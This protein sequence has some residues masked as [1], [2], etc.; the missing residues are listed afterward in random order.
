MS[1]DNR[2]AEVIEAGTTL[3]TA[4]CYELYG[5]PPLG[6][7]VRTGEEAS[8]TYAI[9]AS[10]LTTG[11]EPGR[12]AIARGKDEVS[13]ADIYK[14]NPQLAKLLRSEFGALVV[15][16]RDGSHVCHY[17]PPRPA[18]IHGF[19]YTCS[20]EEVRTF[21]QGFNFLNI[22]INTRTDIPTDELLVACLR[23]MALAYE[24]REVFL[25][26]AGRELAVLLAGRYDQLKSVLGRLR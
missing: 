5:I 15:G 8:A 2:V 23:Q 11:L 25:M 24:D 19:V 13:E 10:A 20:P 4:Q 21:S 3:F 7:L 6:S 17:L 12:R 1:D 18:R 16:Y 22:I 26:A 9:V 14:T